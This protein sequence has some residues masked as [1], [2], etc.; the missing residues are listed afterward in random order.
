MK[1]SNIIVTIFAAVAFLAIA[2][3]IYFGEVQS[4]ELSRIQRVEKALDRTA[5]ITGYESLGVIDSFKVSK[6]NG[7]CLYDGPAIVDELERRAGRDLTNSWT[8]TFSE[9]NGIDLVKLIVYKTG[10][11]DTTPIW[12]Q[13]IDKV[14]L[15]GFV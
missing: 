15:Y 6:Q 5:A 10:K 3:G 1:K 13:E 8:F 11:T 14:Y 7:S 2:M 4:A 9:E 12:E